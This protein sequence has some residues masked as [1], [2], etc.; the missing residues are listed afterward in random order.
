MTK[1]CEKVSLFGTTFA[2]TIFLLNQRVTKMTF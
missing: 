2:S 1:L